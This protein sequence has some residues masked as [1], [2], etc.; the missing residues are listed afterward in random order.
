MGEHVCAEVPH[1]QFVFTIPKRLRLYFRYD[2]RLLGDLCQAAWRSVRTVYQAVSGRPDGVS[3]M[4]GASPHISHSSYYE[5]GS[6]F[7]SRTLLDSGVYSMAN[8]ASLPHPHK[9]LDM[10]QATTSRDESL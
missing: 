8:T 10:K 5:A 7:I 1:R 6:H 9:S 4:V 2:R 3:G